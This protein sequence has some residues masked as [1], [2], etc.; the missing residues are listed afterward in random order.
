[1]CSQIILKVD[2]GGP[3]FP[4]GALNRRADLSVHIIEMSL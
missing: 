1:M 3:V 2:Q 4:V